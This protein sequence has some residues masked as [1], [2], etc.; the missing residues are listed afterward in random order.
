VAS[1]FTGPDE[2][3]DWSWLEVSPQHV[4]YDSS[5]NAEEMSVGVAQNATSERLA[6]MSA[7]ENVH[8]RSW[9]DG[10]KEPG[11]Q[12][13]NYGYNFAVQW[14]RVLEVDPEFG[15]VTGWNEWIAMRLSDW[16]ALDTTYASDG[17]FVDVYNQEYSRDIEPM[18]G[19]HSD[20]YYY[21]LVA[22]VRKFKGA[23]APRPAS[24]PRTV[25]IDGRF[26]AWDEIEPEY[27]DT[28][29]DTTHRDWPGW[30]EL[31]Y[32]NT[33]GRNDIVASKVTYDRENVYFYA[34]TKADL[35][36]HTDPSWMLLFIDADLDSESGWQGYDY[37]VNS[38]VSS[39]TTTSLKRN[40]G[41]WHWTEVADLSY[42]V[43]GNQVEIEIPRALIGQDGGEVVFDFH[44]ADNIEKT[45]DIA[46]FFNS[47]DSAPNRRFNYRFE[48]VQGPAHDSS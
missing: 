29:G 31:H 2:P 33:T 7:K 13:V 15:F 12:A 32:T 21:Q 41:G 17:V 30:G 9:H 10:G 5:G 46:E 4:F 34:E 40:S 24:R 6:P 35:T 43:R 48:G 27:R 19:G 38:P 42:R 26:S 11:A 16:S 1:Y 8:G 39:H 25:A 45:G 36:A 23:R 18:K 22:N 44:W 37:L 47:G 14:E 20:N 3:G 28:A